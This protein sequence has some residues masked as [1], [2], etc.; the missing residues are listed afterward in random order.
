MLPFIAPPDVEVHARADAVARPPRSFLNLSGKNAGNA[1][2]LYSVPRRAG[3][4][5]IL[6][7]VRD[8]NVTSA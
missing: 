5:L 6:N 7:F 1:P 8:Q 4:R 3:E 2:F